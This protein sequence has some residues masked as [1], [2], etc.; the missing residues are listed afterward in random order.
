MPINSLQT[1]PY[2]LSVRSAVAGEEA[3]VRAAIYCAG[4]PEPLR[5]VE[6]HTPFVLNADSSLLNAIVCREAGAAEIEVELRG[7]VDADRSEIVEPV[8]TATG[9]TILLG[10]HLLPGVSRFILGAP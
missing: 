2:T 3:F 6:R 9:S 7:I 4:A 5:F 10:E 8:A 1:Q